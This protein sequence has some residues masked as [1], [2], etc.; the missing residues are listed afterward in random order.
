MKQIVNYTLCCT[1][2][3]L[4]LFSCT[5][6]G[7]GQVSTSDTIIEY[8]SLPT[9]IIDMDSA[10]VDSIS[11]IQS[12]LKLWPEGNYN[13]WKKKISEKR[14]EFYNQYQNSEDTSKAK[15]LDEASKYLFDNLLNNII[16]FWY[17][18][19]WNISGYSNLPNQGTVGCSYFVSNT[20]VASGFNLNRFR[21]A[22]T[23]P[24]ATSHSLTFSDSVIHYLNSGLISNLTKTILK[25]HQEGLYIIGLDIH[26]G[27]LLIYK[28]KLYFIH[29]AYYYPNMVCMEYF[30]K[31]PGI[32]WSN[33]YYITPIT[34]NKKLI[35]KWITK[36]F[37]YIQKP[38]NMP[39]DPKWWDKQ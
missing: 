21:L 36:E 15:I 33:N 27:Y 34:S 2:L 11:A 18:T 25:N 12:G 4:L 32:N 9:E 28:S 26:I 16:P 5:N 24:I 8:D 38:V 13:E 22:Q 19:M 3:G 10:L 30:E 17:Q 7:Q 1:F 31:S 35:E 39:V 14:N 6:A 23:D 20:L 29:S 37:I